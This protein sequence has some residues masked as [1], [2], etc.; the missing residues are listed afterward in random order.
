VR[1]AW[2]VALLVL[3]AALDS[4]ASAQPYPNRPIKIIVPFG[5]G[6]P[7]DVFTRAIAEELKQALNV[8]VVMENRP[9][10]GSVIGTAEVARAAPDGYTLLM[11]SSTQTV[12]ETL[13][14]KKPY[15]LTKDFVPVG[16]L[17]RSDLVLVVHPSV[18]ANNLK[19]LIALA[20]AKPG[21]L[22][23]GSSGPGS[24][25]HMAAELLKTLSGID[26]V[27]VPYKGSTGARQDILGGQVQMMFDSI[28]TMA[29]LIKGGNVRALAVTGK[30]R[31]EILPD[32]PTLDEAGVPGYELTFWT[33]FAAPTGTPEPIVAKLYGAID[34]ILKRP[35]VKEAWGKLGAEPMVMT[36]EQYAAH[37]D[38]EIAKWAKVIKTNKI[39][40][41]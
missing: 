22:N 32:V 33:G 9:G 36:R 6:G 11:L 41:H 40:A 31:S 17:I 8:P 3:F 19:E 14:A 34:A 26:I 20:Q 12:N 5:A 38:N 21:T 23:F 39:E 13:M 29:P 7:T 2:F 28:P 27:H 35:D 18:P 1:P 25:Y 24:N 4:S 16:P 15:Q 10:A 37:I 30:K